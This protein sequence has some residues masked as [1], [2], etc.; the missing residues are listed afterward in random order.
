MRSGSRRSTWCGFGIRVKTVRKVPNGKAFLWQRETV[1]HRLCLRRPSPLGSGGAACRG[2]PGVPAHRSV[3]QHRPTGA[4]CRY[5]RISAHAEKQRRIK[6]GLFT[7]CFQDQM[8]R[9]RRQRHPSS[10]GDAAV[11]AQVGDASGELL[12]QCGTKAW[13]SGPADRLSVTTHRREHRLGS[14]TTPILPAPL[15]PPIYRARQ[16]P[17]LPCLRP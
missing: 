13:T 2:R 15:P 1:P 16:H 8:D 5:S 10:R 12:Q 11:A 7:A 9:L 14:Q 6:A 3:G 17:M 4:V